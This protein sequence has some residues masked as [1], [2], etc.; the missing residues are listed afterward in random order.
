MGLLTWPFSLER[1]RIVAKN[2]V[3]CRGI[4]LE[5]AHGARRMAEGRK[6]PKLC[7]LCRPLLTPEDS[8]NSPLISE[9]TVLILTFKSIAYI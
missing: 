9:A 4:G 8:G 1:L 2:F 5:T 6:I 3:I 7:A